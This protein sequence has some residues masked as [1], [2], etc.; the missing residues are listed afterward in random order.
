[1]DD[2]EPENSISSGDMVRCMQQPVNHQRIIRKDN[3]HNP[4]VQND[5]VTN[6][7]DRESE[8]SIKKIDQSISISKSKKIIDASS[9]KE[10]KKEFNEELEK[11][12]KQVTSLIPIVNDEIIKIKLQEVVSNIVPL[13]AKEKV[14]DDTLAILMQYYELIKEIK[15]A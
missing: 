8:L 14:N 12:S 6:C 10:T 1:M 7:L 15:E 5:S 9:K 13:T 11:G 4:I 3:H 2:F